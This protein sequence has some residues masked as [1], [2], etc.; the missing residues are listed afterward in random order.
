MIGTII[1]MIVMKAESRP[2]NDLVK[3]YHRIT[4]EINRRVKFLI[5]DDF[6]SVKRN[7]NEL[8]VDMDDSLKGYHTTKLD[9]SPRTVV[10]EMTIGCQG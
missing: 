6:S 3:K 8:A 2:G 7:K 1:E 4:E 10:H 9:L 5:E